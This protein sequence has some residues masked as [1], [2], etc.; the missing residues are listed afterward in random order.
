M[1]RSDE[2]IAALLDVTLSTVK[3]RWASIYDC[4][5]E[6]QPEALPE[7]GGG[8]IPAPQTRGQEKRR[9]LLSYLRQHPEELR[10]C[11]KK[12]KPQS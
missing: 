3:K 9:H 5:A 2:E 4:V 1:D 11:G 6:Q 10:P 12:P 7:A 8:A